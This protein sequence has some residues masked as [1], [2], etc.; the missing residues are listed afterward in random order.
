MLIYKIQF[1]CLLLEFLGF[2]QKIVL[3]IKV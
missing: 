1:F 3:S 2:I